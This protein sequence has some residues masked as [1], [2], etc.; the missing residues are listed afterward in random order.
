VAALRETRVTAGCHRTVA[1]GSEHAG[2]TTPAMPALPPDPGPARRRAMRLAFVTETYPPEVNGVATTT[3]HFVEGLHRLGHDLQLVRPRQHAAD[4]EGVAPRFQE[5]LVRGLPIPGY[6]QLRMGAPAGSTLLRLWSLRRP[7]VVHL[8]TE[9]PLGWSALQ[10]ARR[11]RL[12]V[13]SDFRTNF[14]A[15]SRHYGLGGLTRPIVGYLRWFHNHTACTMVPTEALRQTLERDG[16]RSLAVVPRGV[17]T[18]RFTPAR[19]SQALRALWGAAPADLVVACVGEEPRPA[20]RRVPRHP[21]RRSARAAAARRRRPDARG[22]ALGLPRRRLRRAAQ[23]PRPRGALRVG[24]PV[25]VPVS[26]RD[27][28][29]RH[30]RGAGQRPAGAGLRPCR[31]RAAHPFGRQRRAGAVR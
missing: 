15:Y 6:A 7:D 5:V 14:H 9:G 28:R 24:R 21:R 16:F 30:H 20:A 4:R 17:D 25:P 12:P 10:A 26:D 11:L 18:E 31:G 1:D 22:A 27:L 2:M 19:R 3:Q 23:R 13:T 29:Q 8:A